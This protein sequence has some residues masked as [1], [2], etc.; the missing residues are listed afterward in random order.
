M[1][2]EI[3]NKTTQSNKSAQNV[4]FILNEIVFCLQLSRNLFLNL[5][6]IMPYCQGEEVLRDKEPFVHMV[7]PEYRKVVCDN[8]FKKASDIGEI[9]GCTE[10]KKVYYCDKMCQSNAWTSHHK[11]ECRYLK[12][13]HPEFHYITTTN[14]NDAFTAII[15][16]LRII[17]KLKHGK[18]DL[19]YFQ[20]PDSQEKRFYSDLMFHDVPQKRFA[21]HDFY[22][23]F[24][25]WLGESVPSFSKFVEIHSKLNTNMHGITIYSKVTN[26]RARLIF[27]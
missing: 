1:H 9:K 22:Q 18:G 14:P 17:M 26:K 21:L 3:E 2:D 20:L 23:T 16:C 24:E 13:V 8:C 11:F 15:L 10:C 4:K 7:L 6:A 27:L 12:R 25:K 5:E 19:E